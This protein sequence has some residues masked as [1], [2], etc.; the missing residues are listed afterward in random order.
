MILCTWA[1]IVPDFVVAVIESV[2]SS[3]LF[4][5]VESRQAAT[6]VPPV[7]NAGMLV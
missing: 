3:L 2:W 1:Y 5:V 4:F 6:E 7:I